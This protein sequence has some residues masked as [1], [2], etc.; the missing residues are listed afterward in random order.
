MTYKNHDCE[1]CRKK[2]RKKKSN[3]VT[4]TVKINIKK[5]RCEETIE[6]I[7]KLTKKMREE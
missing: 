7:I 4:K 5:T 1:D 3:P 6:S 2:E